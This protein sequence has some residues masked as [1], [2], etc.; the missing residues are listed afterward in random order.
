MDDEPKHEPGRFTVVVEFDGAEMPL[1]F[2]LHIQDAVFF[3]EY[4]EYVRCLPAWVRPS[5]RA[6]A[7]GRS[8]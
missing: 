4:Y 8:R 6:A 3:Q 7:I 2:A 1:A 5:N